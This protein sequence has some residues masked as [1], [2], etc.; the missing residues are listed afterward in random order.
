MSNLKL[1]KNIKELKAHHVF[2][3]QD[4]LECLDA[5]KLNVLLSWIDNNRILIH[6]VAVDHM[7]IL[8]SDIAD[9]ICADEKEKVIYADIIYGFIEKDTNSVLDIMSRFNYPQIQNSE[10]NAFLEAWKGYICQCKK[11]NDIK[12]NFDKLVEKVFYDS[13]IEQMY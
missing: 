10:L 2:K 8:A 6:F 3:S 7:F 12:D 13:V 4:F 9:I 5:S 1:Q 11:N